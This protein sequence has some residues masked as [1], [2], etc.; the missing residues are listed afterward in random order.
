MMIMLNKS[1]KKKHYFKNSKKEK[2]IGML[3]D[4]TKKR[5]Q[6][7]LSIENAVPDIDQNDFVSWMELHMD[8]SLLADLFL[9]SH[10]KLHSL[11]RF[12]FDETNLRSD[13]YGKI[14]TD[15]CQEDRC[16][17][18]PLIQYLMRTQAPVSLDQISILDWVA[19]GGNPVI[20]AK[21]IYLFVQWDVFTLKSF[22]QFNTDNTEDLVLQE[23][24]RGVISDCKLHLP[25]IEQQEK[26]RLIDISKE[27]ASH[28]ALQDIIKMYPK[29]DCR[30]FYF[31]NT[32]YSR[33]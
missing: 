21:L 15:L 8:F 6:K 19:R 4:E 20:R 7:A 5:L 10:R 28:T 17:T 9:S 14:L 32:Y 12:V 18:L 22:E 1:R 25:T 27:I 24:N 16:L 33:A 2:K 29:E 26:T 11:A 3:M 23:T 31:L 30:T 13:E